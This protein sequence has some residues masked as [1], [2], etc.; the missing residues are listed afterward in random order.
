METGNESVTCD[1]FEPNWLN[2]ISKR[3]QRLFSDSGP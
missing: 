3:M 2:Q 1:P